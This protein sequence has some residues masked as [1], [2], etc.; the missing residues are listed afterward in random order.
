MPNGRKRIMWGALGGLLVAAGWLTVMIIGGILQRGRETVEAV[1][2]P[3]AADAGQQADQDAAVQEPEPEPPALALALVGTVV[4]SDPRWS[5]ASILA[6]GQRLLSR[7]G[8][9][10]PDGS[11][12]IR[13]LDDRVVLEAPSGRRWVLRI[14]ERRVDRAT[15][16]SGPIPEPDSPPGEL[17][18]DP[19]GQAPDAPPDEPL[20]IEREAEGI[21]RIDSQ[22]IAE[23]LEQT[24]VLLTDVRVSLVFDDQGAVAGL[25][26]GLDRAGSAFERI[27]LRDGDV[28]MRVA[29]LVI[30][31][32]QALAGLPEL[33]RR[34][35]EV[36]VEIERAGRTETLRYF[37]DSD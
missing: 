30:D 6:E 16:P 19:P 12:L 9:R 27:G 13:I 37:I 36:D 11:R 32:P 1:A 14:D 4:A 34:A 21:Y 3:D 8:D 22:A 24:D 5:R 26:L 20:G 29:G 18:G 35:R 17:P 33:L 2:P 31:S 25:R 10:L 28:L 15:P 7:M 23:A